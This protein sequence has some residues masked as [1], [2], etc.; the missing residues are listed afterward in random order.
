MAGVQIVVDPESLV[1]LLALTEADLK[2]EQQTPDLS[3]Q[4]H[5]AFAAAVEQGRPLSALASNASLTDE[6]RRAILN[7]LDA[8]RSRFK[9]WVDHEF[10]HADER[11]KALADV[12][13]DRAKELGVDAAKYVEAFQRRLLQGLIKSY[14][15][16]PIPVTLTSGASSLEANQ[17]T[18]QTTVTVSPSLTVSDK[19]ALAEMLVSLFNVA[20]ALSIQ[21]GPDSQPG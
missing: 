6:D 12:I 21:Y 4:Q 9:E 15:L 19:G 3:S 18:V 16:G 7:R 1:D 2:A 11:V 10:G 14:L 8:T 5:E 13:F 20:I 17:I